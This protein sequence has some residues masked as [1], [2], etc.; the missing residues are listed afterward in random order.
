[1]SE[2]LN[3]NCETAE[4]AQ[5]QKQAPRLLPVLKRRTRALPITLQEGQHPGIA[6]TGTEP[7]EEEQGIAE[8]SP[9]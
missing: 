8:G 3:P 9:V 1:L 7:S 6:F 2:T 4:A 5:Q